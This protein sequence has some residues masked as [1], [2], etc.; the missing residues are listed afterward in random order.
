MKVMTILGTRP[1][2]IRL[3]R[4]IPKLDKHCD[5]FWSIPGRTMITSSITSSFKQLGVR[6]PDHYLGAKGTFGEQIGKILAKSEKVM[7]QGKTGP[8]PG[9]GRH[10]QR[11]G[12][13]HRQA[14]GH[15]RLS[16]GSRQ[17]LL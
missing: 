14:H 8:L 12:G 2:I 4:V 3:S 16:H 10:Q 1:E 5:Q 13:N 17:P 11:P 6:Q 9:P 15:S 7:S